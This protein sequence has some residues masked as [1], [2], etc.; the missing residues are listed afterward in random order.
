MNKKGSHFF[1]KRPIGVKALFTLAAALFPAT[2][3]CFEVQEPSKEE[4]KEIQK[5]AEEAGKRANKQIKTFLESLA[6]DKGKLRLF[7]DDCLT[8]EDE[9]KDFDAQEAKRAI[10]T[11]DSIGFGK[12]IEKEIQEALEQTGRR[13]T[14]IEENE[15]F[16]QMGKHALEDKEQELDVTSIQTHITPEE[17]ILKTCEEGGTY[18]RTFFQKRDV[19]IIPPVKSQQKICKGHK[20]DFSAWKEKTLIKEVEKFKKSLE[21]KEGKV[22]FSY[23]IDSSFMNL[24]LSYKTTAYWTHLEP[25]RACNQ[26]HIQEE[27]IQEGKETDEWHT[28]DGQEEVLKTL[29]QEPDCSLIQIHPFNPG[30]KTLQNQPVYRDSWERKLI[31][32]CSPK[33]DSK[34]AVLRA[35]GGILQ[36]RKCLK[37]SD[38]GECLKWEKTYDLG[39][40]APFTR[41]EIFLNEEELVAAGLFD[42]SYEKNTDF[43]PVVSSLASFSEM[44][45]SSSSSFDPAHAAVFTGNS[46][47]CRRSFDAKELFD[48][49]YHHEEG[50]RGVFIGEYLGACNQEEKDLYLAVKEGKCKR[51]G[52]IK[53]LLQTKHV[54]CCFPSKLARIVQE[55]GRKQLGLSFGTAEKPKCQGL[56]IEEIGKI[57]FEKID[58][59]DFIED[60]EAKISKKELAERFRALAEDF[61]KKIDRN[62]AERNTSLIVETEKRKLK[63]K[64]YSFEEGKSLDD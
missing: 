47:R 3:F 62:T 27:V 56:S 14:V 8:E 7:Q 61:S 21:K 39:K 45:D 20:K 6:K 55:A 43:G 35:A 59:T 23:Q 29:E 22:D 17:E 33:E 10:D 24:V 41:Q 26:F 42:P 46:K 4:I 32:T 50:G 58:F 16:L 49:C 9:G 11:G 53:E 60:L 40:K 2:G 30:T 5:E 25:D 18:A 52:S 12:H 13:K 38:E 63:E 34:C 15:S 54:F 37:E 36:S 31:F 51:V 1:F 44:E 57:D 64:G 48:C 28:I 19:T